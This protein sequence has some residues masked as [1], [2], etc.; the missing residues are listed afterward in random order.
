[1]L[2]IRS[3]LFNIAFF[4]WSVL[5]AFLFAPCFLISVRCTQGIARPWA[6]VSLLLARAICGITYEIR[7]REHLDALGGQ[8]VLIA[9]KHQSAWDT[10]IFHMLFFC[11]AYILKRSLLLLPFWGWYLWRMEMI[12]IDRS[13][14]ASSMKSMLRQARAVLEK[15]RSIVIFP[16]GT[17]TAPG[18]KPHYHPGVVALYNQLKPTVLPV[19]LNSGAYWGRDAFIKRPGR[20]ILEFLP[21]IPPGLPKEEFA[22]TLE[23]AIES[24][25]GRLAQEAR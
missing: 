1:M 23:Q 8:P 18:A 7:G 17:R 15:N 20:I 12:A 19:A 14:G 25:S 5:S 11:P 6:A 21:P 2:F 4:G 22:R 9:S 10:I 24:A 3:L 16:E 13:A